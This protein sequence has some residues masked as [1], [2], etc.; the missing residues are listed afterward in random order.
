MKCF[1]H[2]DMDGKA[3]AS[4]V[5]YYTGNKDISSYV[6][7]SYD[8]LPSLDEVKED[9]TVYLV[10][11][12]FTEKTVKFLYKLLSLKCDIVWVDHHISS[13]RLLENDNYPELKQINGLVK[14]NISG[15]ALTY[16]YLL[17]KD[18]EDIPYYL[19]LVSDYDCWTKKYKDSDLFKLGMDALNQNPLSMIW[20]RLLKEGLQYETSVVSSI[21]SSG[22]IIQMYVTQEHLDYCASYSYD[23]EFEGY[24]IRV[25]NRRC[26]SLIFGDLINSYPLVCSWVYNGSKYIYSIFSVNSEVDCSRLA[27]KYG[28]GGHKGASGFS[29]TYPIF[30]PHAKQEATCVEPA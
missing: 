21:I 23:A 14:Q 9:E 11:C 6:E 1:Y 12:S 15:A 18:Y 30:E 5:A 7:F 19:K 26:N 3:A 10:D 8:N 24:N 25:I 29:T 4:V 17:N 28:G 27:E 20:A 2:G 22:Q 16:M 13:E